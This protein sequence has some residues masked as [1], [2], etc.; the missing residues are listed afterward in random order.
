MSEGTSSRRGSAAFTALGH[1]LRALTPAQVTASLTRIAL[2]AASGVLVYYSYE[3]HGQWVFGIVGMALCFL[4]LAPWGK[5]RPHIVFTTALGFLQAFTLYAL[6]LPWV[7]EFVGKGPFIALAVTEALYGLLL[8]CFGGLVARMPYGPWLFALVFMPV[9][10]LRAHW[11]FGGFA[12]GRLAWGQVDGPLAWW[13]S[14]GGPALVTFFTVLCGVALVQAFWQRNVRALAIAAAPLALGF[15]IHHAPHA[16]D[17]GHV[18]IAAVQG[19][20]PRMGLDFNAQRRA[21]LTNH[22]RETGQVQGPVDMVFWPENSS[23]VNPFT[24]VQAGALIDSAVKELGAPILVGTI[25]ADQVGDRNTMVVIDPITGAGDSHNKKYLQPFGEYMPMRDFFRN[26][27][28]LVDQAGDFKP[29]NGDGTVHMRA[30][31]TG[32]QVTVG[33]MTCYEVAFDQAG[34]SAIKAGA[35][36]LVTPTNNATFGF[37]DMTY[38]QL[39]MSR[40]RAIEYDRAVVVPAT[41]G[42][43]ALIDPDGKVI[44]Q[45]QIFQ[46]AVLQ[47]DMPLRI[48]RTPAVYLA[49]SLEWVLVIM[50]AGSA[51]IAAFAALRRNA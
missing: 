40:M 23:D 28:P 51:L 34:T 8:G 3:P 10:W 31:T 13:V 1:R 38:Q 35:E 12:W 42:V 36:I 49:N 33:V 48:T 17:S 11:P 46:A 18:N 25:T 47:G 21:V 2:A 4:A 32:S 5:A 44:Q 19:N 37:T 20:V 50:G 6:L 9:E 43:S 45:S 30:A 16:G 39:A 27:S 26:F 41:S 7:G 14:V 15:L 29:G 22:V 24:D